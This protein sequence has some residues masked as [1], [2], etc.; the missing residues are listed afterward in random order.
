MDRKL[1]MGITSKSNVSCFRMGSN[2]RRVFVITAS[3]L[4]STSIFVDTL[5]LVPLVP[6]MM[7]PKPRLTHMHHYC[8]LVYVVKK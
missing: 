7:Q 6:K 8:S 4:F 2:A 1:A 3:M 5:L